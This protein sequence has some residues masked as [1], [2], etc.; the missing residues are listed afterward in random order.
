MCWTKVMSRNV[1]GLHGLIAIVIWYNA[2]I[3]IYFGVC[4]PVE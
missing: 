4:E 2:F 3:L 1:A